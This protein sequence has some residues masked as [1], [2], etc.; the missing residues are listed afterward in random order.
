METK[1]EFVTSGSVT[2]P[3][4]FHA[5][6][7][8]AGIKEGVKDKLDLGILYSEVPCVA[9][10][11]FTANRIKA[12]P[13]VWCQQQL[14]SGKARAVVANSGCANA[15]TGEQG[16]ADAEETAKLVAKSMGLSAEDVLVASTG[17][18]GQL[19]PMTRI[20]AGINQIVLSTDGG[21]DLAGR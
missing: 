20:R 19:L 11:L 13:I 15:C 16:L 12:A 2:S 5:G 3:R 1:I 18:I 6:A 21:H 7:T 17:V 4:G 9:T 8:H 10:A 14:K